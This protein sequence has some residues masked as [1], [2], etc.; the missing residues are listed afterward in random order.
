M[1]VWIAKDSPI[2]AKKER[3]YNLPMKRLQSYAPVTGIFA[4]ALLV[5]II[6]NL[7]VGRNYTPTF[8]AALYNIL[9]RLLVDHGCFCL[10]DHYQSLGRPPLWPFILAAIYTLAGKE[11]LYGRLFYCFLGSGTCT[12]IYFFSRDLF[13]RKIA[14][15][16][17]ILAAIY[18]CLFIYDGWLY[19]ESLYTFCLTACIYVLYRLQLQYTPFSKKPPGE[20]RGLSSV[21]RVLV[22]HR[23][24]VLCG[25]L[26]GLAALARP[27]GIF[28][29]G[30]V[31]IWAILVI[32]AKIQTWKPVLIDT[33]LITCIALILI[34]PW[35]YRNYQVSHSFVLVSTGMGE[36]LTGAY[37]NAVLE[38]GLSISGT[39][40]P[41]SG[42]L[43]H[44]AYNYS[45]RDDAADTARALNWIRAHFSTL[46]YLLGLH[47]V[48]MWIPYTYSHG[49]AFEE[50]PG[51][52]IY[53]I[54]IV[55]IYI[56]ATPVILF[57]FAELF[58]T[59]KRYKRQLLPVYLLLALVILQ[60]VLFY[61]DMRF[62][63]PIEPVLL[64]LAGK[65]LYELTPG[66]MR[67]LCQ[68]RKTS[69]GR[70]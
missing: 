52:S 11:E 28:L 63:A 50:S 59:W 60:N 7:T 55:M 5:R 54:M 33:V 30:L 32:L 40:R 53:Y 20:K 35:S 3:V 37:N 49:L 1:V 66:S 9:G 22:H 17:G 38:G 47:F 65:A 26:I 61:S 45:S 8:D 41:S 48:N 70:K 19:T 2:V 24:S 13:G 4:L 51:S 36:V 62:R 64:L 25:L 18:P 10:Y 42:S 23:W 6:Y 68:L 15:F 12:I 56:L 21:W 69:P 44:D 43:N 29:S 67:S 14:L 46:P 16:S 27:N 31:V 58:L 57:A 39:W 34:L